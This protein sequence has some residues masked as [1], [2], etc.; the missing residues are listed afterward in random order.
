MTQNK[1][2]LTSVFN[3]IALKRASK[4]RPRFIWLL[5]KETCWHS[6]TYFVYGFSI[7]NKTAFKNSWKL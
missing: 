1:K 3:Q 2:K 4:K 5:K 7:H 6:P